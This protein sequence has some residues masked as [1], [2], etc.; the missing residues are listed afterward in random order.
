MR[1][2]SG[3]A[4]LLGMGIQSAFRKVTFE[5][6]ELQA[7]TARQAALLEAAF[8]E[9]VEKCTKEGSV[10]VCAPLAAARMCTT[11]LTGPASWPHMTGPASFQL[12]WLGG[13]VTMTNTDPHTTCFCSNRV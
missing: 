8:R 6:I 3:E 13:P 12:C 5:G 7:D 1:V 4:T 9:A 10:T 2:Q 11:H